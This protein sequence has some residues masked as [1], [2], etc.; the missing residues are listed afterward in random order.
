MKGRFRLYSMASTL[1]II[2]RVMVYIIFQIENG[3]LESQGDEG[4]LMYV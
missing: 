4:P 2:L 1:A 3:R